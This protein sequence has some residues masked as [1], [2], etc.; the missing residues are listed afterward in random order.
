MIS[1]TNKM[2]AMD[3]CPSI[4]GQFDSHITEPEKVGIKLE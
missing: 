2:A 1:Q 4:T 3:K